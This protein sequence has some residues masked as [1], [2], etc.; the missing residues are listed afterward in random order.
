MLD[1][2]LDLWQS[3]I[4]SR[5]CACALNFK[6]AECESP[7]TPALHTVL[8]AGMIIITLSVLTWV[9]QRTK[10]AAKI[11]QAN[12]LLGMQSQEI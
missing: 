6:N 9:P 7:V 10:P 5:P 8:E 11:L 3:W 4:L 12:A 1:S 2:D